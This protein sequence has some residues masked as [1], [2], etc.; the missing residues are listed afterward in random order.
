MRFSRRFAAA[1]LATF[2]LFALP[3]FAQKS[4]PH[5]GYVY[6]A[7]GQQGSSFQVH[8]GGQSLDGAARVH[9]SGQGVQTELIEHV[10]PITQGVA[11]KLREELAELMKSRKRDEETQKKIAA[12]RKKL[13]TYVRKPSSPAIVEQV[14]VRVTVAA[15]ALVGPRE[16]RIA[17]SQGLTNP[18]AFHVGQLPEFS[19]EAARVGQISKESQPGKGAKYAKYK[20]PSAK[21]DLDDAASVALPTV[22]NGQILPGEVDRYRFPASKGEDLVISALAR[23]LIPYVADAVPGW[24]QAVLTLYDADGNEVAYDDDFQFHPDPVLHYVIPRDGEYVLEIK[25]AI[26][27]GREDFVYR[28]SLG[29][30]PFVTSV[31]PL[32]GPLGEHTRVA[33]RGWNLPASRL[34]VDGAASGLGTT[35]LSVQ[36]ET[37]TSNQTLFGLGALPERLEKEPNDTLKEAQAVTLPVIVNGRIDKPGDWDV[38]SFRGRAGE[39]IVAEATARRLGS[40]LDS[41]IK[42]TDAAGKQWA[43]NDDFE[44][45][46]AGLHTHHADSRL[47]LK[48]P[49]KGMYFV[50]IAD[51]QQQGGP[52]FGYRLRISRPQPDFAL[53]VTPSSISVRGNGNIPLIVY[54]LRKDGFAG[55]IQLRLQDPPPGFALSG[56]A[57]A[58]GEDLVRVTLSAA[59]GAGKEPLDLIVQGVAEIGGKEVVHRAVPADDMMQAFAYRHLVTAEQLLVVGNGRS[60]AKSPQVKIA[61]PLPIKIPTGGAAQVRLD[62][63]SVKALS[64]LHLEL[65]DPPE[66]LTLGEPVA[67]D[68]HVEFT[69]LSDATKAKPGLKGNL[70]VNVY[71]SLAKPGKGGASV[72]QRFPVGTLPA[73]SFEVVAK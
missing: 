45:K 70:I 9:V 10:K 49:A 11:K 72:K 54:A 39:E 29:E 17:T 55:E 4:A 6:P 3:A 63:R 16:I 20:T 51:T 13:S 23:E 35:L 68:E 32:G 48:L 71:A 41:A 69:V 53:R 31:F 61:S 28:I 67:K 33:L 7:G 38:F 65:S 52:A 58:A 2:A 46:G 34:D 1:W 18:M 42:V 15:D 73:I 37:A 8:I 44:D 36:G 57:I 30:L 14:L 50:H 26:Y 27:R 56:G 24:F 21:K 59:A 25:D 22:V 47:S 60:A 64:K 66:G 19:E 62:I 40:P 43:F 5:I 12:L